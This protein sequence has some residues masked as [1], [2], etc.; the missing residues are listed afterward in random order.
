MTHQNVDDIIHSQMGKLLSIWDSAGG[1]R[2]LSEAA[3]WFAFV[4]GILAVAATLGA[5]ILANRSSDIARTAD[6][7]RQRHA[8]LRISSNEALAAVARAEAATANEGAAKANEGLGKAQEE[9]AIANK[10]AAEARLETARLQ[11]AVA[12]RN[13]SPTMVSRLLDILKSHAP[14][15]VNIQ[16]VSGDPETLFFASQILNVF[17]GAHWQVAASSVNITNVLVFDV[18]IIDNPSPQTNLLRDAFTRAGIRFFA[19]QRP[20]SSWQSS[21]AE[22]PGAPTVLIGPRTPPKLSSP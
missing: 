15:T 5:A 10:D 3:L 12:W 6:D 8:E 7:T 21:G 16:Y 17:E 13:L 14:G 9:I 20:G 19:G 11:H 22:A 4:T 18:S 1:T 2:G